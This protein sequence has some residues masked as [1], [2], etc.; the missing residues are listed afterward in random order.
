VSRITVLG[1][2]GAIGSVAVHALTVGG[3]FSEI[4]IAEK[5][6]EQACELARKIDPSRITAV[7]VDAD[8]PDSIKRV[9]AG[10]DVVL[11]CIGPFY[12]YGPLI[13]RAV[14]EA[15]I[16]FV[17]VCDDL[18]ATVNELALDEA[19]RKAGVSALMGMGNSPGL[20][21]VLVKFCA[22]Q[23]LSQVEAVDIYHIHGGEAVEG[24]AVIEHRFHAMESDIPMFID[25][26]FVQV[27]MLEESGMALAQDTDFR[28]IG[29]Y[30]V[31]PYPHPETITLPRYLKGVKRVTNLGSV[32]PTEYFGM[33]MD[34]IRL[35]LGSEQVL[36]VRG[37]DVVCRQFAV[38]FVL[39][40]REKFLEDACMTGPCGCLKVQVKGTKNGEPHTYVF[41]MSSRSG[42]VGEGT[43]IP[44]GLGA[45]LMGQGRIGRKGVFPPEAAIDPLEMLRLTG[46]VIQHFGMG[47]ALPF[48]LEHIDKDGKREDID[49]RQWV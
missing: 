44:A 8:D 21:N 23:L 22:E 17:D 31:Y 1:G 7:E 37:C 19:A 14:I 35:G 41:S 24:P 9:V 25:G 27:R 39:A 5:R 10:S 20:G 40:Q 16:N 36:K 43:G 46:K 12:R 33:I 47:G 48:S 49:L 4:V 42:G 38:A 45:I 15:G 26:K 18:D 11:N 34:V 32:L 29:T 28:G 30:R 3:G 13:L 2:C 6:L